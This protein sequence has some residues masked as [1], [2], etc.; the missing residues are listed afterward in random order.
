MTSRDIFESSLIELSKHNAPSLSLMEFNYFFNKAINQYI[1]KRYSIYYGDQQTTDDIRVLKSTAVLSPIK[2]SVYNNANWQ[3]NDA[4]SKYSKQSI[5]SLFGGTYEVDLPKDYLHLLNCVCV[6]KVLKNYKCYDAGTHVQFGATKLTSDAWATI[7]NDFY[8]RPLPWRP[9]F[10]L[11]NVNTSTSLP[12]NPYNSSTGKGTDYTGDYVKNLEVTTSILQSEGGNGLSSEAGNGLRAEN[13]TE[14]LNIVSNLS[15][16]LIYNGNPISTRD[17]EKI[18]GPRYGNASQV[19]MEV[20]CGRDDSVFVLEDVIIDYIKT[21]QYIR[22]T[23]EQIDLIED[24]SQVMEFPDYVCQEIINELVHIVMENTGDPH[25]Q[26]HI[27]ISTS[28]VTPA[29]QQAAPQAQQTQ[30]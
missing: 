19:R 3:T 20:R 11:H 8:N 17:S 2:A 27:P 29:Q 25:L 30:G 9:Y 12:T 16:S 10:Y 15:D 22:L 6:F 5:Q 4:L 18:G 21:P 24:T 14:S 28:I 26:S 23:Q 13:A 7:I 1:N